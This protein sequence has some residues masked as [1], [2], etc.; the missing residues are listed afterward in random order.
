M[1][2]KNTRTVQELHEMHGLN[3]PSVNRLLGHI[4]SSMVS[5]GMISLLV[6]GSAIIAFLRYHHIPSHHSFALLFGTIITLGFLRGCQTWQDELND[7][8]KSLADARHTCIAHRQLC[9]Q[10]Q[11]R[12]AD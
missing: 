7:Y 11:S 5:S 2:C 10:P 6:V 1:A 8:Q 4:F 12:S 3:K 9:A